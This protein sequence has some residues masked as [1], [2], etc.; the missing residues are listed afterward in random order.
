MQGTQL[1]FWQQWFIT[2]INSEEDPAEQ[3]VPNKN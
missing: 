1:E 3:R 2:Q